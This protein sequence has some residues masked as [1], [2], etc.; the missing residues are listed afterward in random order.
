MMVP[1]RKLLL[2]ALLS[3][4]IVGLPCAAE[5]AAVAVATSELSAGPDRALPAGI[6]ASAQLFNVFMGLM[7]ILALIMALAWV[8]RRINGGGLMRQGP[9]QVVA[10]M[11]LGT[12][13]RLMVVEVGGEQLLI[14]VTA[15]QINC[16]HVFPQPVIA[17][18]E[19]GG[20]RVSDFGGKL[21]QLLQQKNVSDK[22]SREKV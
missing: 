4:L 21:M 11:P 5:E 17:T 12:R 18:K 3:L 15:T 6:N 1:A 14:G 7:L 19:R 13:E 20:D 10:A 22:A 9:M 8:A 2:A 16:L